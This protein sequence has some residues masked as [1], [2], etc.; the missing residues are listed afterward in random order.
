MSCCF[1]LSM[2]I[3]VN[4]TISYPIGFYKLM[5]VYRG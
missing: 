4:C 3:A 2:R 5:Y 1:N